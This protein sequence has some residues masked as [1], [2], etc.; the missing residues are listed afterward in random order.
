MLA[1]LIF[2]GPIAHAVSSS[3]YSAG[4]NACGSCAGFSGSQESGSNGLAP[5]GSPNQ[6][7]AGS[8]SAL[9]SGGAYQTVHNTGTLHQTVKQTSENGLYTN[10]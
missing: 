9:S 1:G 8:G 6:A 3:S 4:G 2:S 10:Q 7:G 5:P